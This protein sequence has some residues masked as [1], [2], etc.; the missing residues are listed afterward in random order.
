[1]AAYLLLFIQMIAIL[2]ISAS[3]VCKKPVAVIVEGNLILDLNQICTT[4]PEIIDAWSIRSEATK[5]TSTTLEFSAIRTEEGKL[6]VSVKTLCDAAKYKK[7]KPRIAKVTMD[8]HIGNETVV[9][10]SAIE[11][12]NS[13]TTK[14][15]P[16]NT[17]EPTVAPISSTFTNTS[18]SPATLVSTLA[19]TTT[20]LPLTPPVNI[21]ARTT[22]PAPS[23]TPINGSS[24]SET[25]IN[26]TEIVTTVLVSP[27]KTSDTSS[28]DSRVSD[29]NTTVSTIVD[30]SES[31]ANTSKS[32]VG[33]VLVDSVANS[34]KTT[35]APDLLLPITNITTST[36]EPVP[37][38]AEANSTKVLATVST[39]PGNTTVSTILA[40][41]LANSTNA[42][43]SSTATEP[44]TTIN[45][46]ATST[47]VSTEIP[48][49]FETTKKK[50]IHSDEHKKNDDSQTGHSVGII[51][52]VFFI[53]A[54]VGILVAA[55]A[56]YA[57]KRYKSRSYETNDPA[58]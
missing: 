56:I 30:S 43:T 13:T 3:E 12:I 47:P 57:S 58:P 4:T 49:P 25:T 40:T 41:P 33:T 23:I 6:S 35:P 51:V 26:A 21:S 50:H 29:T 7:I 22:T 52:L 32:T 31:H 16:S 11:T 10:L 54:V 34:T 36:P 27:K 15:S 53:G 8:D 24:S 14:I 37:V 9:F 19:P 17:S 5:T 20:S 46:T 44:S 39:S 1:M 2:Q 42:T 38:V 45:A 55:A 48:E 28:T 18:S